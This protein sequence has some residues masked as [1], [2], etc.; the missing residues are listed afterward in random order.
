M[1]LHALRDYATGRKC[2]RIGAIMY[3]KILRSDWCE[4]KNNH[5]SNRILRVFAGAGVISD[6]FSGKTPCSKHDR[7]FHLHGVC[8]DHPLLSYSHH[9]LLPGRDQHPQSA[10]SAGH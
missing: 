8:F 6:D 5:R 9:E 2:G 1:V 10:L 7:K 3:S 4:Y